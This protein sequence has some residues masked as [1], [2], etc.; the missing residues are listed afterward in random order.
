[1]GL[2]I[3]DILEY[4]E[5]SIEK[6]KGK[7]IAIDA[8]NMI[9]QFLASIRQPDGTPLKDSKGNVTSHLKGLFNRCVFF[10]KNNIMPVFV[11]DGKPPQLKE[12]ERVLR[13][14]RKM[15]AETIYRDALERGD[16]EEAKK[17][18]S[19]TSKITSEIVEE[20]KTLISYFGFPIVQAYSEGEAEAANLVKKGLVWATASQDYDSLLFGSKYL[21]RNLSVG[22]KR[23]IP[24]SNLY[25]NASIEFYDL[26]KNLKKLDLNI[27]ELIILGILIGTDFNPGGIKG[28]GPKKALKL[29]KSY[30][31]NWDELFKVIDWYEYFSYSWTEVYN[32]FKNMKTYYID[33]LNFNK[34]NKDKII[35]FL[36]KKDFNRESIEKSLNKIKDIKTLDNFF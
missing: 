35:E 30:R 16:I 12:K 4:E 10:K 22:G 19:R 6:I 2:D 27:D 14:E 28:I 26:N 3:K 18:A 9:Y 17:Y 20:T 33:S 24:G 31:D 11:F 32:I 1:M 7:K 5:I 21:I 15:K 36:E 29:V 8:F 23:K 34:M 13:T 25:K